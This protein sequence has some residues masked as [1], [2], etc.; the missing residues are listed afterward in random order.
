MTITPSERLTR[1]KAVQEAAKQ[2]AEQ[3]AGR[4]SSIVPQLQEAVKRLT[5]RL[6][7]IEQEYLRNIAVTVAEF[8]EL[9]SIEK[10]NEDER[11]MGWTE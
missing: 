6:E 10:D 5:A 4:S 8:A 11:T 7:A 9:R 2:Q 3:E 1:I